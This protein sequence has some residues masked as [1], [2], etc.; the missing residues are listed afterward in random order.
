MSSNNATRGARG[1]AGNAVRNFTPEQFRA[2]RKQSRIEPASRDLPLQPS[3]AQQRL[4]FLAQMKGG[5][6]AYHI[7]LALQLSGPLDRPALQAAL[8]RLV[9]RH[10]ALRTTFRTIDGDAFQHI[11]PADAGF[12]LQVHDLSG[13]ADT[14]ARLAA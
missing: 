5:S 13:H 1:A 8:D 2:L 14:D 7:P 9:R 4:W 12:A 3:F 11:G 10:E 6:E